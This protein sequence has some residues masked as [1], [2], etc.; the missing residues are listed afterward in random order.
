MRVSLTFKS[1]MTPYDWVCLTNLILKS[2]ALSY[3]PDSEH[4][5]EIAM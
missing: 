4:I 1:Y 2:M 5:L 3:T